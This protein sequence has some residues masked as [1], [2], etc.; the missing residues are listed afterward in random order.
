MADYKLTPE[1]VDAL[2]DKLTN[3]PA[4]RALF[5]QDKKAAFAQLPGSPLPPTDLEPGCCLEPKTL[6][7][8]EKLK[9]TREELSKNLTSFVSYLPHLLEQ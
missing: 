4:Y 6:A 5:E 2:L 1:Q 3:D 8:P 7:S 9:A